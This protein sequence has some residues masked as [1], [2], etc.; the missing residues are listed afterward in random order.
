[1][2]TEIQDLYPPAIAVDASNNLFLAWQGP[3]ALP[4][5]TI[6]RDQGASWSPPLKIGA[7][8]VSQIRRLALT[9]RGTGHIAVSYLGSS[10][11]GATFNAYITESPERARRH[12]ELLERVGERPVDPRRAGDGDRDLRRPDPVP[13]Q[14]DR[15]RRNALG[16]VPLCSDCALSRCARRDR[17]PPG[18]TRRQAAMSPLPA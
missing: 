14:H 11:A 17:R 18:T 16:G 4:Y 9:A 1:M 10:D 2:E 13:Q 6:S 15:P 7:P 12:S 8:G 5:L 3:G